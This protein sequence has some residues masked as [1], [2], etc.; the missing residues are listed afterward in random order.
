VFEE[1][2]VCEARIPK[3]VLSMKLKGRR[4]GVRTNSRW[5]GKCLAKGRKIMVGN[6][7]EGD[8]KRRQKYLERFDC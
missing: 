5:L 2:S 8:V 1:K 6:C 7:G 3:K 4:P